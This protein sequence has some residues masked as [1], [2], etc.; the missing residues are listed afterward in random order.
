MSTT[1]VADVR[2]RRDSEARKPSGGP[3][4]GLEEFFADGLG[5]GALGVPLFGMAGGHALAGNG[6]RWGRL[7]CGVIAL[8]PIP[9]WA[10]T[11]SDSGGPDLAVTTARGAWTALYFWSY[12]AVLSLG[13]AIPLRRTA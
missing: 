1:G 9:I 13:C 8:T 12:L 2:P 3:L 7:V 5:G 11:V 4:E 10:L 6:R